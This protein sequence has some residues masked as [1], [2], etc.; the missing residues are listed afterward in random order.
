[1]R[2][3]SVTGVLTALLLTGTLVLASCASTPSGAPSLPGI[4]SSAGSSTAGAP[5][6]PSLPSA[7]SPP[8]A[9]APSASAP[10]SKPGAP[11]KPSKPATASPAEP[12]K[13]EAKPGSEKAEGASGK[14]AGSNPGGAQTQEERGQALDEKLDESLREFDRLLMREQETLAERRVTPESAGGG[15]GGGAAGGAGSAGAGGGGEE[16]RRR[17]E[18]GASD[19]DTG[20]TTGDSPSAPTG[21]Q[22]APG[23]QEDGEREARIP[24]DVGDGHDDDIV[25]RQLREAAIAE[26]DPALREKLWQEYRDYK[27]GRASKRR[28]N[29]RS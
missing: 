27:S 15:G 11:S 22:R 1:M 5:S 26:D 24:P 7:P 6:A 17:G 23:R 8:S 29:D 19:T 13:A 16:G 18:S 14:E 28:Q 21:A 4:P 12:G 25:A 2:S 20:E 3:K 9:S 10:P